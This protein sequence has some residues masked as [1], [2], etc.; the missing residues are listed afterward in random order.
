M[1]VLRIIKRAV[2]EYGDETGD[3][4]PIVEARYDRRVFPSTGQY[5]W[6]SAQVLYCLIRYLQPKTIVEV[7]TS[8]GYSTIIQSLALKKNESGVIHTFEIDPKLA[9]SAIAALRQFHA[10]ERVNVHVGDARV[11]VDRLPELELPIML[12]LD[13]LHTQEFVRWFIERWVIHAPSDT[14]F[15]VHDVMPP[16]ARVRFDG[17]PPW[18]TGLREIILNAGRRVLG[19]PTLESVGYIAPNTFP[20]TTPNDLPTTDGVFLSEA[21]FVNRLVEAMPSGSFVYLHH[22]A[23]EYPQLSPRRFDALAIKRENKDG[24]PMEWNEAVWLQSGEVCK[25]LRQI[26]PS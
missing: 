14:L 17:G 26:E 20:P 13:S 5:D 22:L 15:H 24:Q 6:F 9:A 7:S 10:D 4:Q 18:R 11:E 16:S 25:A 23:D 19:R 12:F 8:S 21:V 1:D 2:A 3:L